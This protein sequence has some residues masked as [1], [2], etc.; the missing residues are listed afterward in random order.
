MPVHRELRGEVFLACDEVVVDTM[1]STHESGDC[2]EAT[3]RGW[4]AASAVTLG[5]YLM[6]PPLPAAEG[7]TLFKSIGSVEQ[8]LVLAY[9]LAQEAIR[10]GRGTKIT[11][12][13]SL[14]I[15]R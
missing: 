3:E 12:V 7:R 2:I 8:D 4:D 1:D 10:T 6:R 13:A 14:R 9:Y 11:D 5:N 15:M